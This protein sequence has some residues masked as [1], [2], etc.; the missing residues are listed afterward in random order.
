MALS[1]KAKQRASFAH[2]PI[3]E[4]DEDGSAPAV[5]KEN[6]N[7]LEKQRSRAEIQSRGMGSRTASLYLSRSASMVPTGKPNLES[8]KGTLQEPD[9]QSQNEQEMDFM[10]ASKKTSVTSLPREFTFT[11][12]DI[13]ADGK[14][15]LTLF[16]D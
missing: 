5:E 6:F 2:S 7:K 3:A 9:K 15:I 14:M 10:P 16:L 1:V 4:M 13:M 11:G 8:R 12:Y